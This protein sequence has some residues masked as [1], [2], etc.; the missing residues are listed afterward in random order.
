MDWWTNGWMDGWTNANGW[1]A[2]QW[3]DEQ[4]GGWIDEQ[5]DEVTNR[6]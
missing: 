6:L 2:G 3:I 4:M 1:M 5:I